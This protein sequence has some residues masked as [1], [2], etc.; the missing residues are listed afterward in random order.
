VYVCQNEAIHTGPRDRVQVLGFEEGAA[1]KLCI[2]F[3]IYNVG[4]LQS[5]RFERRL[6]ALRM[7]SNVYKHA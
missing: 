4:L 3:P 6:K 2:V 1:S 7:L 5:G